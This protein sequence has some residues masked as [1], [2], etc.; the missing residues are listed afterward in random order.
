[1]ERKNPEKKQ[2]EKGWA[3]IKGT[4]DTP[5]LVSP[6]KTSFPSHHKSAIQN[7]A[8]EHDTKNVYK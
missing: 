2:G 4:R 6:L 8:F 1:M 7:P 3:T 5:D